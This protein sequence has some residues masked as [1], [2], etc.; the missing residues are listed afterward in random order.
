MGQ[1]VGVSVKFDR[2]LHPT[3][4]YSWFSRGSEHSKLPWYGRSEV[5]TTP[6]TASARLAAFAGHG[7]NSQSKS[8]LRKMPWNS[9]MPPTLT[10]PTVSPW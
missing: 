1:S 8:S 6:S 7:A 2:M 10:A 5:S 3:L 4:A 9:P